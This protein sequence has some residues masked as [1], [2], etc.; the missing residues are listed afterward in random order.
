MT[1][2]PPAPPTQ[3][4]SRQHLPR[5]SHLC[6]REPHRQ[7]NRQMQPG[8]S[9]MPV[10]RN[11]VTLH[12]H[13][14]TKK[15]ECYYLDCCAF[16]QVIGKRHLSFQGDVSVKPL[17][18]AMKS[19]WRTKT[20]G[21]WSQDAT[22]KTDH[23]KHVCKSKYLY[24]KGQ[25]RFPTSCLR[26]VPH[27]P[28]ILAKTLSGGQCRVKQIHDSWSPY[29]VC[30]T[31]RWEEQVSRAPCISPA[32]R[33]SPSATLQLQRSTAAARWRPVH[34]PSLRGRQTLQR[35][36]PL[37]AEDRGKLHHKVEK[38]GRWLYRQMG[39]NAYL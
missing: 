13:E 31:A 3:L 12:T 4:G 26:H 32:P 10:Y 1:H 18:S 36:Y 24:I 19:I 34:T 9:M 17:E 7:C 37:T 2:H 5:G 23:T 27:C 38:A 8:K 28:A 15:K 30:T 21:G 16:H 25:S 33:G 22:E 39:D 6:Q 11:C 14:T 29:D 35:A 20:K